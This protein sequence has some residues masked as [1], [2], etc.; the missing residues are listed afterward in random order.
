[1]NIFK[2]SFRGTLLV[3]CPD[4]VVLKPVL[5]RYGI[6]DEQLWENYEFLSRAWQ[7]LDKN[8][9]YDVSFDITH[10]FRSLPIYNLSL[11]DYQRQIADY[12]ISIS[13]VYYGN[14]EISRENCN[15]LRFLRHLKNKYQ[16]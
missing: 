6:S 11:L 7:G 16:A 1:M 13:H 3:D 5:L 2:N 15:V 10:S 4:N 14:A 8:E 12:K 9:T